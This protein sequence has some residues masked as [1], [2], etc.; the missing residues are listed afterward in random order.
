MTAC[1]N[2][3]HVDHFGDGLVCER[4]GDNWFFGI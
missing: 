2:G 1:Q 3:E 4:A